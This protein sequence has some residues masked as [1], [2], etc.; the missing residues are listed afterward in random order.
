[1][2]EI[3]GQ[4]EKVAAYSDAQASHVAAEVTWRLESEIVAAATSTAAMAD[5]TTCIVVEGVRRDIQAQLDQNR[6]DA[7]RREE[8]TQRQVQEI[9]N[10]MQTLTE[11]LNKFKPTSEHAVGVL[12]EKLSDQV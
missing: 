7:L 4:V 1:M 8:E 2:T 12:Q 6:A 10:Q 9:S 3:A 5:I 11:Q